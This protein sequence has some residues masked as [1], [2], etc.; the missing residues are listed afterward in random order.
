MLQTTTMRAALLAAM[1]MAA[2]ACN[3][4]GTGLNSSG[5]HVGAV[6]E[7]IVNGTVSP[8]SQ[9][10]VVELMNA[11]D[12]SLCTAT[13]IAP[14]LLITAHHCVA[15][16]GPGQQECEGL[17]ATVNPGDL[18]VKIN[19]HGTKPN[20]DATQDGP[21]VAEGAQI[22][23]PPTNNMCS[24][25]VALVKLNKPV[26]N[27]KISPLRFTKLAV[28]EAVTVV[29]FGVDQLDREQSQRMQRVTSVLGVGAGPV[30]FHS[31]TDGDFNFTLPDGDVMT[32]ESHCFGDSGGPLFDK[33]GNLV[34][35]VSRGPEFDD[36]RK[37]HGNTCLDMAETYSGIAFN[38][39]FIQDA[40]KQA[41][42]DLTTGTAATTT[43][44]STQTTGSTADEDDASDDRSSSADDEEEDDTP[45][46]KSTKKKS[47]SSSAAPQAAGCS[48]A[49]G[50]PLGRS[51][52]TNGALFVLVAGALVAQRSRAQRKPRP[53]YRAE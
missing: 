18:Q 29:G 50:L 15:A 7:R 35:I 6:S 46:K 43:T 42:H 34:A 8:A 48:A 38:A 14:D 31:Q 28:N 23:V 51:S 9:D 36:P 27:A 44:Q 16:E 1:A 20:Y 13:L 3:G 10:S 40:A 49:P 11:A 21:S 45:K 12:G 4:A 47:S 52:S 37:K 24:F 25:D 17:G 26:P 53:S 2:V 33:D 19:V 39:Q 22:F 32:G 5:E 30:V 41:G